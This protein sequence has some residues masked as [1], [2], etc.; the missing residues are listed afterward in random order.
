MTV[1]F[2]NLSHTYT[3]DM[4]I[5][6][7]GPGGQNATICSDAGGANGIVGATVTLDDAAANQLPDATAITAGAWRPAKRA[8]VDL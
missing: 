4:D 3:D 1:T 8:P 5:M 6:L 2:N 7:V